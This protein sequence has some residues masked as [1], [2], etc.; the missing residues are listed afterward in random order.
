MDE[1]NALQHDP[2]G[3][4]LL[5]EL[6]EEIS[7]RPGDFNVE[8]ELAR[9]QILERS[10]SAQRESTVR[11]LYV[12]AQSELGNARY[13]LGGDPALSERDPRPFSGLSNLHPRPARNP[14]TI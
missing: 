5:T 10:F 11:A 6:W 13:F 9:R 8:E 12:T 1:I 7:G 3:E 14:R 2:G 4:R